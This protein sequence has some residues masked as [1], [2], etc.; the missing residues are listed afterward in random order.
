MS[1]GGVEAKGIGFN[2]IGSALDEPG[3]QLRLFGK[4]VSY[5]ARRMGVAI[6]HAETIAIAREKAQRAAKQV[7]V[8]RT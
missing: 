3:T 6:A 5:E 8:S 7:Q 4:P 2:G 1:Y